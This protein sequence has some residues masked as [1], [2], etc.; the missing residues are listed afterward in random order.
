MIKKVPGR[1]KAHKTVAFPYEAMGE[2]LVNVVYHGSYEVYE[3]IKGYR[4]P[5]PVPGI[6]VRHLQAGETGESGSCLR[7]KRCLMSLVPGTKS[8]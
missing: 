5:G 1:A 3:P 6:E 7:M 2:A 8:M 4:Y